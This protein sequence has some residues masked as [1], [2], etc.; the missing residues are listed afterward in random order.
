MKIDWKELFI[1]L[2]MLKRASTTPES[3][4]EKGRKG[5]FSIGAFMAQIKQK[6]AGPCMHIE[7]QEGPHLAKSRHVI[8]TAEKARQALEETDESGGLAVLVFEGFN[9]NQTTLHRM[10]KTSPQRTYTL[11]PLRKSSSWFLCVGKAQ[12]E[13]EEGKSSVAA[14][15]VAG[16][17]D[18]KSQRKKPVCA[19]LCHRGRTEVFSHTLARDSEC[20]VWVFGE[21]KPEKRRKLLDLIFPTP[22]ES[23]EKESTQQRTASATVQAPLTCRTRRREWEGFMPKD[24][25]DYETRAV[26]EDRFFLMNL[27]TESTP[28]HLYQCLN[29][30]CRTSSALTTKQKKST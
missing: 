16:P 15:I 4:G 9:A 6:T 8:I 19:I 12:K 18:Q 21:D 22:K 7:K 27:I 29:Q 17:I 3:T 10:G 20:G 13:K 30:I 1:A 11:K 5:T 24:I 26:I 28:P 25:L 14:K 23:T 2:F